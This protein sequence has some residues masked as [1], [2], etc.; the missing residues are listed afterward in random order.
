[1][2]PLQG[3]KGRK[4]RRPRRA[5]RMAKHE[6]SGSR[7]AAFNMFRH[8]A[9]RRGRLLAQALSP[10]LRPGRRGRPILFAGGGSAG[11]RS[12]QPRHWQ[13]ML[14]ATASLHSGEQSSCLDGK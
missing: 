4:G 8:M 5:A 7:R 13:P 11:S 9:A 14:G 12:Q 3:R 1:M 6:L 2:R 10:S